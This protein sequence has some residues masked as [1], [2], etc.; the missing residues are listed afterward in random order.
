MHGT[1][2]RPGWTKRGLTAT[3]P[4]VLCAMLWPAV[5]S[6]DEGRVPIAEVSFI[7][8]P[9]HYI[10]TR[11]IEI[12]S[13]TAITIAADDVTLDL[14][15]RLIAS[16]ATTGNLISVDGTNVAIRNGRIAGGAQAIHYF[17][18][19]RTRFRAEDLEIT[20]SQLHGIHIEGAEYAEVL[21]CRLSDVAATAINVSGGSASFGGR[22]VGNTAVNVGRGLGLTGLRGGEV[23]GNQVHDTTVASSGAILLGS[24][25]AWGAG[26]NLLQDNTVRNGAFWGIEIT[27]DVPDN[28]IV[29]N[30]VTG[31]SST[32]LYVVSDGNHVGLN[33]V[34]DN[35]SSGIQ[36]FGSMTL[37][38][39]NQVVG[40]GL[41]G[42][43]VNGLYNLV[44]GNLSQDNADAGLSF[45]GSDHA[46]RNNMLRGNAGGAVIGAGLATDA[47]GNVL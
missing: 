13:G 37:I 32:G 8:Q 12:T 14:N 24:D 39:K 17:G 36:I 31:S 1:N 46:Y 5:A 3:R 47:G 23:R 25:P 7:G 15:G 29:G 11:D 28:V 4:V 19:T 22:F 10:V 27:A 33:I 21:R 16:S 42:I 41:F 2:D 43:G 30:V 45:T 18:A 40:N 6:A 38:R 9:G 44:E 26:G 34:S 35:G 20:G